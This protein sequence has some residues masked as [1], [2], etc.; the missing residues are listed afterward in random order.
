MQSLISNAQQKEENII[1]VSSQSDTNAKSYRL[2]YAGPN[3]NETTE[4]YIQIN[5]STDTVSDF[6]NFAIRKLKYKNI[7]IEDSCTF[8]VYFAKKNGKPKSDLPGKFH[9]LYNFHIFFYKKALEKTQLLKDCGESNLLFLQAI[10][11]KK[12]ELNNNKSTTYSS[13]CGNDMFYG[14]VKNS[15]IENLPPEYD[16]KDHVIKNKSLF[17][18]IFCCKFN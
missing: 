7:S 6:I 14:Y 4:I 1:S 15:L 5:D 9:I 13:Y 10:D 16:K 11:E 2:F 8:N 18:R 12:N 17:E 3:S